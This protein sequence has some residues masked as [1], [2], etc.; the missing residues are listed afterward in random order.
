MRKGYVDPSKG[1]PCVILT[2]YS[3]LVKIR[4]QQMP[5]QHELVRQGNRK[6]D[7]LISKDFQQR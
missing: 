1:R 7:A 5:I 4:F 3:T 2:V 6:Y